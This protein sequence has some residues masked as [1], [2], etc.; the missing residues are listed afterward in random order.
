MHN[1]SFLLYGANGYTGRLIARFAALY[2]LRPVLAGRSRE[3]LEKM[4]EEL[5]LSFIVVNLDDENL[6]AEALQEVT[7]V[8][9]AAGPFEYTAKQMVEACI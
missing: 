3:P 2:N 4:A 8:L 5:N 6:L 1:N 9:H 7:L